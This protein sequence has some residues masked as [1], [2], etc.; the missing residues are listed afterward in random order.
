M[1]RRLLLAAGGGGGGIPAPATTCTG[2]GAGWT[3]TGAGT[4]LANL[5]ATIAANGVTITVGT[6][7]AVGTRPASIYNALWTRDHAY[8]LWHYPALFTASE[9]RQFVTYYLSRRTTGAESDP[10]GGT[11]PADFI[12]DRIDTSGTATYKN[13]GASDLPF[14]DGIAFVVLAL[15]SDW[16]LTGDDTTFLAQQSAIDDCLAA[17][18]RS[19]NGCVYSDPGAPSVDYGFTD[20]VKKTGD[21][22]YGTALQAWAYKMCDEMSGGGSST[23]EG[24]T[25]ANLKADAMAGLATL[26]Q[27]SGWYAGSSGNNAAKD[28]VWVTALAV[29]E[30]LIADAAD[31][32]ASA[33][34]IADTY[35]AGAPDGTGGWVSDISQYGLVRHLPVGQYWA[36]TSTTADTYQNG[37]YWPT[38]V[39]DCVRAV[40]TVNAA[41]ARQWVDDLISQYNAERTAEGTWANVPYEWHNHLVGVGA[42]GYTPHAAL[43][44]RFV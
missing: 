29:A 31:C 13:A 39:W 7:Q 32:R 1:I 12:A 21:V 27:S 26:R 10:D 30:G 8:A 9:R 41:L 5:A 43:I 20:T 23:A 17:I 34:L 3:A 18:P 2:S 4:L 19:G 22:A 6:P 36:G 38:P 42:K 33:Q 24:D 25:Y 28:D 44:N 16:N 37:G 14:M 35:A 40:D 15:W 11:L